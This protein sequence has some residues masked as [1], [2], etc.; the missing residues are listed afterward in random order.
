MLKHNCFKILA[1]SLPLLFIPASVMAENS[2]LMSGKS[3]FDKYCSTCHG[4][5]G[6]GSKQG[7]PLVHKIYRPDHHADISFQFAAKKGV[8]SHHWEFGNMPKVNGVNE[9]DVDKIIKYIRGLQKEAG[10]Y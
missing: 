1:L 7:P 2:V 9:D 5:K 4:V 3:L 8:R 10:I 6:S